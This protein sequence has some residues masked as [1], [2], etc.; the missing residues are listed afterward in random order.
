MIIDFYKVQWLSS[1]F[2]IFFSSFK[3]FCYSLIFLYS[4]FWFYSFYYPRFYSCQFHMH[5]Q[6]AVLSVSAIKSSLWWLTTGWGLSWSVDCIPGIRQLK[7]TD[8]PSF[9]SSRIWIAP[10]LE[11]GHH[12]CC[13]SKLEFSLA[14]TCISFRF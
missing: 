3:N 1:L 7:K 9:S 11:V 13:F 10:L 5:A 2:S 14:W 4:I 8:F 12:I 6:C